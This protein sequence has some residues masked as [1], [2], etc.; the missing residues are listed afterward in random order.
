MWV[1]VKTAVPVGE[2]K[3]LPVM[4][5]KL[6]TAVPAKGIKDPSGY[7]K[8]V[9]NPNV[10]GE[11]HKRDRG[12]FRNHCWSNRNFQEFY[13]VFFLRRRSTALP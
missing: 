7:E 11:S 8:E 2:L 6:R 10:H 13:V 1:R 5:G 3:T 4:R 9:E 12:E